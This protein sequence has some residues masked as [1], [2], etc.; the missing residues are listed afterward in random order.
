M[1]AI[2]VTITMLISA[3]GCVPADARSSDDVIDYVIYDGSMQL[4]LDY[5]NHRF[6]FGDREPEEEARPVRDSF[7]G[8][9]SDCSDSV[10]RCTALE[11]AVFAVPIGDIK[12][13]RWTAHGVKFEVVGTYSHADANGLLISCTKDGDTFMHFSYVPNI[14]VETISFQEEGAPKWVAKTYLLDGR[15]GILNRSGR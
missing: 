10:V 12:S 13:T 15:V 8:I 5:R 2:V 7:G 1:R 6:D 11:A 14:G 3:V 4:R 9:I